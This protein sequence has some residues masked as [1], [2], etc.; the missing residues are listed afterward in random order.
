LQ[1]CAT[2]RELHEIATALEECKQSMGNEFYEPDAL[3]RITL[4]HHLLLLAGRDV[5]RTTVPELVRQL[6]QLRARGVTTLD[7]SAAGCSD[8]EP[9]DALI[10]TWKAVR[11]AD[12]DYRV[13]E[14][15]PA[16]I[17]IEKALADRS[18]PNPQI[19]AEI[20]S[21][22]SLAE[23]LSAQLAGISQR[24]QRLEILLPTQ[25]STPSIDLPKWPTSIPSA[26]VPPIVPAA[27][28]TAPATPPEPA[29]LRAAAEI[30]PLAATP[31]NGNSHA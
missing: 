21:L 14:F 23:R 29:P 1:N 15:A 27:T 8:Q 6:E 16:F 10:L 9:V 4:A 25:G 24:V 20:A 30:R 3:I 31:H 22:R 17:A 11:E 7:C 19:S 28:R 13:H 18:A 26:A 12:I 2:V 5:M